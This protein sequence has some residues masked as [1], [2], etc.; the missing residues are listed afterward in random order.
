[1]VYLNALG[2]GILVVGNL[3]KAVDLL[4]KRATNCSDRPAL[5]VLEL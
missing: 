1:M 5:V 3:E 2:V 4:E